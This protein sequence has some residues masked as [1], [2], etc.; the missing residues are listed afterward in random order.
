M[1]GP[2]KDGRPK[3]ADKRGEDRQ[4]KK[5]GKMIGAW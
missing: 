1:A 5:E 3:A 2:K 4:E